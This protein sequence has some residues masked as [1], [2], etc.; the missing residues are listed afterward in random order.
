[1]KMVIDAKVL[2]RGSYSIHAFLNQPHVARLDEVEDVCYFEIIDNGSPMLKHGS[3]D[4]GDVFGKGDWIL[5]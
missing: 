5:E 2:V 1:M 4:Y 3:Y